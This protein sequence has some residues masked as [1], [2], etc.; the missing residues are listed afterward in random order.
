MDM[1]HQ[2]L[3]AAPAA[4]DIGFARYCAALWRHR[5]SLLAWVGVCTLAGA[6]YAQFAAPRYQAVAT[7]QIE[8]QRGI[9]R[10]DEADN[11]R[12][13]PPP[14]AIT[15]MQLLTSR[16]VVGEVVDALGL[17]LSVTPRRLPLLGDWLARRHEAG[18]ADI[19]TA[20]F[21]LG[22]YGWGGERLRIASLTVPDALYGQPLTLR[23][24]APDRFVLSDAQGTQ[25]LE[26]HLGQPASAGA[27]RLDIAQ[28]RAYPGTEFI[29]VKQRREV[30]VQ[31]LQERLNV[32][33]RGKRSG[34]LSIQLQDSDPG[35]AQ[36]ILQGI[37]EAYVRQDVA[38]NAD[39]STQQL[40]FLR[41][42]LPQVSQRLTDGRQALDAYQR[43]QGSIAIGEEA[44]SLLRQAVDLDAQ[45]SALEV[46]RLGLALRFTPTHPLY[47]AL[48]AR[49]QVL[50]QQH[51]VLQ[52]RLGKLPET[53][54]E[55]LR[56]QREVEAADKLYAL[57]SKRI[58]ELSVVHA[59][60]VSDVRIID[61]AYVQT[62]PVYPKK[63]L[64]VLSALLFGCLAGGAWVYLRASLE[65]GVEDADALERL[66]LPLLA[67]LPL[68]TRR[69]L[70]GWQ[71]SSDSSYQ[72][73]LR[74]LRTSLAFT[75]TEA[76]N[77]LLLITSAS[78]AAGKST[79]ALQ[80]ARVLA[81]GGTRVLLVDADLRRGRLHRR[82][83][84]PRRPGLADVL[85]GL[86]TAEEAIQPTGLPELDCL[87]GGTRPPNP[88]ELL[89]SPR[90]TELLRELQHH[91]D[92]IILDTP[93]V[94]AVTDA[95]LLAAQAGT[96][97]LVTRHGCNTA[98][99]IEATQRQFAHSGL[100]LQG[101]V[102]NA[103]PPAPFARGT[104]GVLTG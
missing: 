25:V 42:E 12:P 103:V 40:A 73:A 11:G 3:P 1:S 9:V 28:L 32:S 78:P 15:E 89:M 8:Y 96:S 53:Q 23:A 91:Y 85:A 43:R 49:R 34:I 104:L 68:A 75:R 66:G 14:E 94:L 64:L 22:H 62:A 51:Q 5:R 26:G 2:A 10:L 88:A 99:E 7:V 83:Q 57:M 77:D 24:E 47:Q 71:T 35:R 56:R 29:L 74:T 93:P 80:L 90:C 17:D 54:Q 92:L 102:L 79:V 86:A 16:R 58:Q 50:N 31:A 100:V 87:V 19:A 69:E 13:L 76:R 72:E 67:P 38:R 36:R 37:V 41:H 95:V 4:A 97:L 45:L 21:G 30:A 6:A 48:L 39:E 59:G 65:R 101:A 84:L 70:G 33:E 98:K 82:L 18:S 46:E 55:L 81:E 61:D 52:R 60:T 27:L 20:R 63:P 44:R